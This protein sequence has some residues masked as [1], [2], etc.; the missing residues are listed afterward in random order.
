MPLGD[1]LQYRSEG[2]KKLYYEF[3]GDADLHSHIRWQAIKPYIE[4][5]DKN[6]E[7]G[8]DGD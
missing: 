4:A 1:I 3:F 2:I 5:K 8:G 7:I 6:V